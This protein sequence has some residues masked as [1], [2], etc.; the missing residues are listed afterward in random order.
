MV[1][2][3]I[4]GKIV[5]GICSLSGVLVIALPVPVIVSNFS[6]IY[7]QN[8]RADKRK[9]QRVSNSIDVGGPIEPLSIFRRRG[10]PAS[11]SPRPPRGPPS[12]ARRRRR[13]RASRPRSPASSWTTTTARRTSSSCN[14]T[15]SSGAWRRRRTASSSSWRCRTT[16]TRS[17]P[18][19]HPR[20]RVRPTRRSPSGCCSPAAA[21][22]AR[23]GTSRRA[24]STCRP[25]RRRRATRPAAAWT[26]P[27]W[28]RRRSRPHIGKVT[29]KTAAADRKGL[30]I[31]FGP[32]PRGPRLRHF[33]LVVRLFCSR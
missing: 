16:G 27:I 7:H 28:W 11:A 9:A 30:S 23:G 32:R 20:W 19:R 14:T 31:D 10:W 2:A 22:A 12:S 8:Q 5:G 33:P 6:R 15:T 1:P 25:R 26:V 29:V 18:G 21:G 3:T 13:R 24:A 17:V 4:A